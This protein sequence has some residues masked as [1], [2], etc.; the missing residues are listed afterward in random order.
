MPIPRNLASCTV[1]RISFLDYLCFLLIVSLMETNETTPQ[2]NFDM[3]A[4]IAAFFRSIKNG[5]VCFFKWLGIAAVWIFNVHIR[6]FFIF[7]CLLLAC[8]IFF[9]YTRNEEK[10]VSGEAM[11]YCNGFD[12]F[13]LDQVVTKLNDAFHRGNTEDLANMLHLSYDDCRRLKEVSLSVGVDSDNDGLPNNFRQKNKFRPDTYTKGQI[14]KTKQKGE[15]LERIPK[16]VKIPDLASIRISVAGLET[17]FFTKAADTILYFLN[18][19]PDLTKQY[20]A[21]IAGLEQTCLNYTRQITLLDSLASIEY[22]ENTRKAKSAPQKDLFMAGMLSSSRDL[23]AE[24]VS[25]LASQHSFYYEDILSLD[26]E[27]AKIQQRF[28][29]ATAPISVLSDFVPL[30]SFHVSAW[31]LT[32]LYTAML[33][34]LVI[35]AFWD[36]RKTIIAYIKE[37][38]GKRI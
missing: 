32:A 24:E 9:R 16:E 3:L 23:S 28:E 31:K 33:I 22:L 14:V 8:G 19:Q 17:S 29:I 15:V 2:Q 37:Q 11:V 30:A 5:I 10:T 7:L 12:N 18:H 35:G 13:T 20:R 25:K 27:R 36:N 21:Y 34:T 6:Y 1:D 26:E 4:G 38:R